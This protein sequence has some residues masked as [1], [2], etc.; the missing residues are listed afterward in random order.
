MSTL[1]EIVLDVETTGLD[2]TDGHRI[3]EIGCVELINH[4]ATGRTYQ[5]YMNP[6][7]TMPEQAFAVHGLGDAFLAN[8]PKFAQVHGDFLDFI[9]H[10]PLVIHNAKFDMRFLNHELML[11][12]RAQIPF[13]RAIDTLMLARQK[14]P[15][16]PASLDAL[17]KRFKID[18]TNREYHGALLDSQLLALV[19]LELIGGRQPDFITHVASQGH[20]VAT[21]VAAPRDRP[22]RPPRLHAPTPEEQAAHAAFMQRFL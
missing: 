21:P 13:A 3:V 19:Y 2:P 16:S 18:N 6:E 10:A 5:V 1:R 22:V 12:G 15:G 11:H 17:C 7:R 14:F 20:A 8:Q 4:V 9:G